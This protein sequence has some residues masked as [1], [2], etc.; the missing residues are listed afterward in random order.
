MF[1]HNLSE[2]STPF[3][4]DVSSLPGVTILQLLN[5]TT[6][7][8]MVLSRA[9]SPGQRLKTSL[10]S[11]LCGDHFLHII[12]DSVPASLLDSAKHFFS[13]FFRLTGFLLVT[14]LT[15]G[16]KF[17]PL[18]AHVL[19]LVVA[20]GGRVGLAGGSSFSTQRASSMC[21]IIPR[22]YSDSSLRCFARSASYTGPIP[23]QRPTTVS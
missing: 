3:F 10:L 5:G 12:A 19:S 6:E 11:R 2:A 1:P 7:D 23:R 16:W 9:F 22:T 14:K 13:Q 4:S 20:A 21:C 15:G 8:D 17:G 18:W